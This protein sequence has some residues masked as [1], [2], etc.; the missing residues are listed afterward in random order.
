MKLII[1]RWVM[2]FVLFSLAGCSQTLLLQQMAGNS[3][4]A[5][6][7]SPPLHSGA[8]RLTVMLDGKTYAGS[9]GETHEDATGEQARRFGWSK[10][11]KHKWI[12]QEMEFLVGS[13][14]LVAA[15]GA[16]LECDHLRHGGDWRLR[17][18]RS[19]GGE[20]QLQP[21]GRQ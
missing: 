15:D 1:N 17:C 11:H 16:R 8:A 20:I 7:E 21:A 10:D 19:G 9:A 14:V 4:T 6:V 18:K 13:T 12:K 3:A 5:T 2:S